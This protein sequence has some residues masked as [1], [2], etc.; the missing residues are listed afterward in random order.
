MTKAKI[1]SILDDNTVNQLLTIAKQH[2]TLCK[3][4]MDKTTTLDRKTLI[5]KE[6]EALRLKRDTIIREYHTEGLNHKEMP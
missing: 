3:E 2:L 5:T 6:I 1:L 4:A